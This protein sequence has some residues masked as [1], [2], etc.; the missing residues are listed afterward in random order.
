[1]ANAGLAA[2]AMLG[3]AFGILML[4]WHYPARRAMPPSQS[5]AK[6][7]PA[8]PPTTKPM[9]TGLRPAP[10][11]GIVVAGGNRG[12]T[13]GKGKPKPPVLES[14]TFSRP[15]DEPD[16]GASGSADTHYTQ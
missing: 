7:S 4:G 6:V 1:M 15:T 10:K 11:P 14:P 5:L 16:R 9:E 8:V 13:K 12:T 2:C 3:L